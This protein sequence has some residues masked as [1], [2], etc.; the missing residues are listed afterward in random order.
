MIVMKYYKSQAIM[1]DIK[2]YFN[3]YEY[4]DNNQSH[5]FFHEI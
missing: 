1:N 4:S 5:D 3:V 2:I